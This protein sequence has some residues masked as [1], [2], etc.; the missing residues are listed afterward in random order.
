M[1]RTNGRWCARI[2]THT[3][4]QVMDTVLL[5]ENWQWMRSP[6][7]RY[8]MGQWTCLLFEEARPTIENHVILFVFGHLLFLRIIYIC[9]LLFILPRSSFF[10]CHSFAHSPDRQK[11]HNCCESEKKIVLLSARLVSLLNTKVIEYWSNFLC[12]KPVSLKTKI[13]VQ[14]TGTYWPF[15]TH[16]RLRP[17]V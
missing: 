3:S 15:G 6:H 12:S 10:Y 1:Y 9:K 5:W 2:H 11:K 8:V 7:S 17:T 4:K 13:N 14:M 16:F